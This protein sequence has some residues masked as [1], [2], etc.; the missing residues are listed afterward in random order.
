M[1]WVGISNSIKVRLKRV[2]DDQKQRK[3]DS[4]DKQSWKKEI[5][6]ACKEVGTYKP[7]FDSVIDTLAKILEDRDEADKQ[8][9]ENGSQPTI[10]HVNKAKE[11]NITK[12]PILVMR[13]ELN[14]QALAFWRELGLTPSG[15][16]K[17]N[18]MAISNSKK[19]SSLEKALDAIRV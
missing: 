6:N 7:C 18:D 16:K 15:L 5:E 17:I 2:E 14:A 9:I 11:S 4:M 13:N 19:Q 3:D 8:Y 12:N 1:R 10:I